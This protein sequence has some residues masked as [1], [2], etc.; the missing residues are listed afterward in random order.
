L[1][2]ATTGNNG[3][4]TPSL[5]SITASGAG[6]VVRLPVSSIQ[7]I[8]RRNRPGRGPYSVGKYYRPPLRGSFVLADG[9]LHSGSGSATLPLLTASGA[10]TK[11]RKGSGTP[12][13]PLITASGSGKKA[14]SGTG[15][16]NL[17]LITASGSGA[18]TAEGTFSGS[19]SA[20]LPLVTASGSAK[21]TLLGS[22]SATLPVVTSSG[23][24]TG[25][26]VAEPPRDPM[27]GGGP[28]RDERKKFKD[29]LKGLRTHT[30]SGKA[31]LP[32][33]TASGDGLVVRKISEP[34]TTSE[35]VRKPLL[36]LPA[37]T[38]A[39]EV[40]VDIDALIARELRYAEEL[41]A[42]KRKKRRKQDEEILLL[43]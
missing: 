10:G 18:V 38:K 16:P 8:T 41:E 43:M 9:T 28:T 40:P 32:V 19:G 37:K 7:T 20:S 25:P 17:P 5:P 24:G 23:A 14:R 26:Q 31:T 35:A 6:E 21:R 30:G 1:L 12:S 27:L 11:A 2:A 22:G 39:A 36:R 29:W 13:L 3:S 33:L 4:G 42:Q 15:S 34:F